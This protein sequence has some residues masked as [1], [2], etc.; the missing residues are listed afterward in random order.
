M[1]AKKTRDLIKKKKKNYKN[2]C[3]QKQTQKRQN[4]TLIIYFWNLIIKEAYNLNAPRWK[5]KFCVSILFIELIQMNPP[6]LIT[7]SA[8][9]QKYHLSVWT[10]EFQTS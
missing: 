1:F 10:A 4:H 3:K 6:T 9:V 8:A 5:H 2:K 7:S